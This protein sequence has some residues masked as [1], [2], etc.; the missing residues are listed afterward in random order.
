MLGLQ[1]PHCRVG[2]VGGRVCLLPVE[3]VVGALRVRPGVRVVVLPARVVPQEGL[4]PAARGEVAVVAEALVPPARPGVRS[5]VRRLVN[6]AFV[7]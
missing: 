3:E 1:S 2:A 7:I 4:E 5:D 6:A